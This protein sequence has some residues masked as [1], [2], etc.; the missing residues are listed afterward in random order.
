MKITP[1]ALPTVVAGLEDE[2]ARAALQRLVQQWR[3]RRTRNELRR[4]YYDGHNKLKDLGISIPPSLKGLEVVIGWPAK[5]VDSMSRRTILD[6]FT[7]TEGSEEL[8]AEVQRIWDDNFM[9][10][11]VP[12]AHTSALMHS[13]VFVF[14]H[15]GRPDVGEPEVMVTARDAEWATGE[16]N[17]RTR[18]LSSAL[19]IVDIDQATGKPTAMNLYLPGVVYVIEQVPSV[20]IYQVVDVQVHSM[21]VPVE[22]IPYRPLLGRPFGRSRITRGV[23][24]LTDS[25]VRT[26]LR[27][28]VGAEFYNA[29]QRYALGAEEDAFVDKGG[30][31]VPAWTVMLGRLLT[32]SRD[33]DGQLPTVGQFAQQSMQPNI[34]Q[35]RSIAQQFSAET[36]LAVGSLGIVQDNPSSAEAIK[37]ANDELGLEIEHWERTTLGPAWQRIMRRALAMTSDSPAALAAARSLRVRWG[38]WATPTEVSQAQASQARVTAIPRLAE[39][40]VELERMGY[41]RDEIERIQS[42]WRRA[43]GGSLLQV[44]AAGNLPAGTGQPAAQPVS[45]DGASDAA[46]DANDAVA[47]ANATKAKADAMGVLIRAGVE[48]QDAARR[49]GLEGV[50]FTGAVPT[51]QLEGV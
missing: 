38:S 39:T 25:A 15:R 43:Q 51:S 16:W 41:T 49:V 24:Y 44:L 21:G 3:E 35:L 11:E 48:P 20:G 34:E 8:L 13:C 6:S 45:A 28:E 12:A 7:S 30:N 4:T 18:S 5:A 22:A 32:L 1:I 19:S 9:A 31:P 50:R 14:V 40:E 29:P 47:D 33:E 23:M 37:A 27:T 10:A 46:A 36:S 42:E 17:A 2:A 26:M